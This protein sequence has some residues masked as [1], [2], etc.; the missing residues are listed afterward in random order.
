MEVRLE[1]AMNK[2]PGHAES[3][4]TASARIDYG[5]TGKDSTRQRIGSRGCGRL[6]IGA[7]PF[8]NEACKRRLCEFVVDQ[9]CYIDVLIGVGMVRIFAI[10]GILDDGYLRNCGIKKITI[11]IL[12][13][14][15]YV[16]D[17]PSTRLTPRVTVGRRV[18][19]T[20]EL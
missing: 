8:Q 20:S 14:A 2:P 13:L 12:H 11:F 17:D 15:F 18:I 5:K 1:P 19:L 7:Q 9:G 10:A 16:S 4:C 6:S 3:A